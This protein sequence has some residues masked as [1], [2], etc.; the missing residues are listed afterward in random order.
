MKIGKLSPEELQSLILDRLPRQAAN[1]VSGPAIGL[2]CASIRFGDGQVVLSCDPITGATTDIGRLAVH[3]ACNDIA[4][5]GIRPSILM[6]VIIAPPDC[7]ANDIRIVADQASIAAA[8]LNVSI[9]GGHTEI[10]DAVNRFI[11]TTTALGFTYGA[12][13]IQANGGKPGDC[14]LMT[15]TAGLEGTAVFAADHG[16]QL[17]QVLSKEDLEQAAAMISS[18][19][20]VEEGACGGDFNVHAMHDATEGGILGACWELAKASGLGCIIEKDD[21]PVDPLTARI[22]SALGIDPLRLTSSGSLIMATDNPE[23]LIA[24]LTARSIRCT[25]IGCLTEACGRLLEENGRQ[26]ELMPPGP[27]EL[28]KIH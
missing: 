13:M 28:Y 9:V 2:D 3:I 25:R 17:L 20:V 19:S 6:M 22:C 8:Q 5:C 16:K 14:L 7:T 23:P 15:K 27:D 1:V 12:G 21:I 18:I 11:I 24:E 26:T 10:S 4:A